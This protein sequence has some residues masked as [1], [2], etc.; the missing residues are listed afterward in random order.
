MRTNK[1]IN[2]KKWHMINVKTWNRNN[3]QKS[4]TKFQKLTRKKHIKTIGESIFF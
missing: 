1:Y 3:K 2:E 4:E